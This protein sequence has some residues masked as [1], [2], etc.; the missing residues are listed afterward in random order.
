MF[1]VRKKTVPNSGSRSIPLHSGDLMIMYGFTR[2]LFYEHRI[3]KDNSIVD[4]RINLTFR[5]HQKD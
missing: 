5:V 3:P 2:Q 4:L 1:E